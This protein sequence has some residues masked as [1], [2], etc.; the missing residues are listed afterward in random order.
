VS[1][2]QRNDARVVSVDPQTAAVLRRQTLVVLEDNHHHFEDLA[3]FGAHAQ[4]ALS[5]IFRD[6]FAV[7]DA[8]GWPEPAAHD[9]DAAIAVPLTFGHV[10]QLRRRRHDLGAANI[11]RLD[12][13]EDVAEIDAI[14][15][16]L[17]ADRI[18]AQTLDRLFTAYFA[19]AR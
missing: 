14:R 2:T 8:L 10:D 13:L 3:D 19:A 4:F 16:Q 17:D 11:D 9:D 1:T 18:A 7:L 6:A 12:G 5:V 15:P